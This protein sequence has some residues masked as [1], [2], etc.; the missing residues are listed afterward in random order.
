MVAAGTSS[1]ESRLT[2]V[3]RWCRGSHTE[4][5]ALNASA[6]AALQPVG[7][8]VLSTYRH[9][10]R[11]RSTTVPHETTMSTSAVDTHVSA[12]VA[13]AGRAGAGVAIVRTLPVIA[14][15]VA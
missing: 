5:F 12:G 8:A 4:W 1:A 11:K 2:S 7:G 15:I 9:D 6:S 14:V 13:Y 3:E 10:P